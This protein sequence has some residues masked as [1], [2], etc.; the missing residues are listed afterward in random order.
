MAIEIGRVRVTAIHEM[1]MHDM[2][3]LIP[4]ATPDAVMKTPWLSP[5]YVSADG[6]I[7]GVIQAF[8][9]EAPDCLVVVDTCVGDNKDRKTAPEWK[10]LQSGFMDRFRAAGFDPAAVTHVLCTHMHVDHVGWNTTWTGKEWVPTFPNAQYLFADVELAFWEAQRSVPPADIPP[11]ASPLEK[12]AAL[13][14][15]DQRQTHRDSVQPI[16]DAGLAKVVSTDQKV[17]ESI[18]LIPTPGHTPGHVAV[19]IDSEGATAV[20][21]GDCIHHPCQIANPDWSTIVDTDAAQGTQTRYTLLEKMAKSG[22]LLIGTHFAA[23]S[24]GRVTPEDKGFRFTSEK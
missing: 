14:D 16:F 22:G 17:S 7:H 8:I 12:G 10:M 2:S 1:D 24:A 19:S 15:L 23:P 3:P 9:V 18:R 4:A 5:N 11:D 13:F 21:T 6:V 20:I